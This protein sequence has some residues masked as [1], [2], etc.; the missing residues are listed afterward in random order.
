MC[1]V[2]NIRLFRCI[3]ISILHRLRDTKLF[4]IPQSLG[5]FNVPYGSEGIRDKRC[6]LWDIGKGIREKGQGIKDKG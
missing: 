3:S 6:G 4:E 5:V 2:I 1:L